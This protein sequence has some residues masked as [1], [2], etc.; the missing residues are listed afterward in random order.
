MHNERDTRE[1]GQ[2]PRVTLRS[3]VSRETYLYS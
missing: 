2:D 1:V 3:V